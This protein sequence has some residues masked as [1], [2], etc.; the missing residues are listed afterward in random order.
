MY[1]NLFFI[2]ILKF[3]KLKS[4]RKKDRV[5]VVEEDCSELYV[6]EDLM[7]RRLRFNRLAANCLDLHK[8]HMYIVVYYA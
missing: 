1:H 2:S 4:D 8:V 7:A 3:E 6:K 5:A